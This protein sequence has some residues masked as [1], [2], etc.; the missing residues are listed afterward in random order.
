MDN[1]RF[2]KTEEVKEL[3]ETRGHKAV[4]PDFCNNSLQKC[5]NKA[6]NTVNFFSYFVSFGYNRGQHWIYERNML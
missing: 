3:I 5:N 2:H 4:F 6:K 1:V